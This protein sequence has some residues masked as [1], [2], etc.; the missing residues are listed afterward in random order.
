MTLPRLNDKG[1][2]S[3]TVKAAFEF[4]LIWSEID[5]PMS[6]SSYEDHSLVGHPPNLPRAR[7]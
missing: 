4:A 7:G 3:Q 6:L 1:R 5:Q 2:Q